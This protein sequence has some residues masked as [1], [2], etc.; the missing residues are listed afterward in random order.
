[1]SFPLSKYHFYFDG[2]RVIAVS[3]YAGKTVRGVAVCSSEDKFDVELGKRI[4]A[5]KC[6]E[7]I[8]KKRF[9]RAQRKV[10]EANSN[11]ERAIQQREKMVAYSSDAYVAYNDAA[12]EYDQLLKSI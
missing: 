1:M 11:L 6:N 10:A 12:Q 5:A 9:E 4:A 2:P 3:T 7:K 8:A